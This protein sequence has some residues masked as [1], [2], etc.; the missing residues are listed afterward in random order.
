MSDYPTKGNEDAAAAQSGSAGAE[1][2]TGVPPEELGGAA[3]Q[4]TNAPDSPVRG[5]PGSQAE[6]GSVMDDSTPVEE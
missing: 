4:G 3:P 2:E 5:E 1:T 6:A